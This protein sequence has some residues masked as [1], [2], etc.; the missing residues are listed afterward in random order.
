MRE[1]EV[2]ETIDDPAPEVVEASAGGD[3]STEPVTLSNVK[4]EDSG[5]VANMS[6]AGAITNASNE[7]Q[8]TGDVALAKIRIWLPQERC[9]RVLEKIMNDNFSTSFIDP[10]DTDMYDDY[11]DI[12]DTPMC[13]NDVL[14]NLDNN[15]YKGQYYTKF[16][17]D[18]RLIWK[19]CKAYNLYK[20]QIWYCA[21]TLSLQFERLYQAW[22]LSYQDASLFMTDPLARPWES[23]CRICL[24][25]EEDDSMMLCD[26]CDAPYHIYCLKPP[27]P[28]VPEGAWICPRC[29]NW[30]AKSGAK[31]LS[32][33]VEE[34]ARNLS[35]AARSRKIVKVMKKKY[36]VKWRGLSYRDCT[37]ESEKDINDDV[38][39]ANYHKLNDTPP[40]E[41]PLTQ[42]EIGAELSKDKRNQLYPAMTVPNLLKDLEG[43]IYAQIRSYHFLKSKQIPPV[44]L[45][46]ESG[47]STYG[48]TYGAT[49]EICL[50]KGMTKLLRIADNSLDPNN[51]EEMLLGY[52]SKS[53][54]TN[55]NDSISDVKLDEN[56]KDS[57]DMEVDNQ[58]ESSSDE[59]SVDDKKAFDAFK[60]TMI[61]VK[62]LTSEEFHDAAQAAY[63]AKK[64]AKK[65][66]K[67]RA[68]MVI[69][70]N[71]DGN[72][73]Q[74]RYESRCQEWYAIPPID[75]PYSTATLPN[76]LA[77][78]SRQICADVLSKMV[79][80]IARNNH[81]P[82][83]ASTR[84]KLLSYEI[85]VCVAKGTGGLFMNIGDYKD[86]VVVLGF[87][88]KPDGTMGPAEVTGKIKVGDILIGINGTYVSH[89]GFKHIIKI[90]STTSQP[91]VYLRFLR[92][93]PE[94]QNTI[95]LIT[96]ERTNSVNS[97]SRRPTFKRS[98]YFGVY[99]RPVDGKWQA[100]I[101]KEDVGEM[102][103]IGVYENQED[104][105]HAYDNEYTALHGSD[106]NDLAQHVNFTSTGELTD[107]SLLL[108]KYYDNDTKLTKER[109]SDLREE[110]DQEEVTDE[111]EIHSC[112][113]YDSDSTLNP[114][115]SAKSESSDSDGSS[116]ASTEDDESWGSDV[117]N[118]VKDWKPKDE[119]EASG[120]T[121]RLLRAVNQSDFAPLRSE[122]N[123]YIV[124]ISS[125]QEYLPSD[126]GKHKKVDQI[127]LAS[128]S[129]I[130]TWDTLA[131]ASRGTN[132][133]I[134]AIQQVLKG[135]TDNGGGFKWRV[136]PGQNKLLEPQVHILE[137]LMKL[138]KVL[139]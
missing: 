62:G 72:V 57:D 117:Q 58:D 50:P 118:D 80:S 105:A 110:Y 26:H 89:I 34:D 104:A 78:P 10:V 66:E 21:H 84:S 12:V 77:D 86:R 129:V 47:P 43:T 27:L 134:Y 73:S 59:D 13:L 9:R 4:A 91:Y 40:E 109:L 30:F 97:S 33:Q 23:T 25:D 14:E 85:E 100:E 120:P 49:T 79:Y 92:I 63:E 28:A 39:I 71:G 38:K 133:P 108:S 29:Q 42:A 102:F 138:F 36:L 81:Q 8:S 122:W 116:S 56:T 64:L 136:S 2:L 31:V 67:K 37:W 103:V 24:L 60:R 51:A 1:E 123:N 111:R 113:S 112:D 135:K 3:S 65:E 44:A 54:T 18:M 125:G 127:D 88:R 55:D 20:S 115:D 11:L 98:K 82:T 94:S 139:Y 121:G 5:T 61:P 48:A 22:V 35:I 32:A 15:K 106:Q 114:E 75:L 90:L 7:V 45:L 76:S 68:K 16:A 137:N 74:E 53:Q 17:Y 41:P 19:N 87:R 70:R 130:R 128:G 52:S 101:Y 131:A 99:Y 107:L 126:A 132:I 6:S 96:K 46:K 83:L 124:D 119:I 95:D 69:V 93:N